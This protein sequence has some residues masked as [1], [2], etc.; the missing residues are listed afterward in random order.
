MEEDR[1]QKLGRVDGGQQRAP[2]CTPPP[3]WDAL[4]ADSLSGAVGF[5]LVEETLPG[6]DSLLSLDEDEDQESLLD[7]RATPGQVVSASDQ[8]WGQD[9]TITTE[10]FSLDLDG[11][12]APSTP[13]T[14]DYVLPS[15]ITFSPDDMNC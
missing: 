2:S 6:C 7:R 1:A 12:E 4:E 11:L 10:V 3:P 5:S 8:D 13:Q 14:R 9:S 15:L